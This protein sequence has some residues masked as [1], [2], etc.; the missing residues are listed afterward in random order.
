MPELCSVAFILCLALAALSQVESSC[1]TRGGIPA[2]GRSPPVHSCSLAGQSRPGPGVWPLR[3]LQL[4]GAIHE[5]G[6]K[7]GP[8][9]ADHHRSDRLSQS[10]VSAFSSRCRLREVEY[11]LLLLWRILNGRGLPNCLTELPS[12]KC[13]SSSLHSRDSHPFGNVLRPSPSGSPSAS[14]TLTC[15]LQ[16]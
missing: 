11:R 7:G 9:A 5:L 14:P 15:A 13:L 10:S 16:E 3:A 1:T 12:L 4:L 8:V 2:F 6:I